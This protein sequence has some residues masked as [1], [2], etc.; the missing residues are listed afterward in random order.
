MTSTL[1]LP[2]PH[3]SDSPNWDE[4]LDSAIF[5]FEDIQR[6]LDYKQAQTALRNLVTNLDLTPQ[7]KSGLEN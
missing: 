4:E 1:P 2:E 6:S 7:E 3:H 5:S